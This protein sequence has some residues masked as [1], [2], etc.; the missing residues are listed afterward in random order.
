M[1]QDEPMS[2]E[3]FAYDLAC[4]VA[5]CFEQIGETGCYFSVEKARGII[6]GQ[7]DQRDHDILTKAAERALSS[8]AHLADPDID[9]IIKRAILAPLDEK[10]KP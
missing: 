1:P 5:G 3:A 4:G 7:I 6:K 8:I 10:V 2:A 9:A